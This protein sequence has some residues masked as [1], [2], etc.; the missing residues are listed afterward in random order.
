MHPLLIPQAE[1]VIPLVQASGM[2]G[3]LTFAYSVL[4]GRQPGQVFVDSVINPQTALICNLSGFYFAFGRPEEDMVW[5]LVADWATQPLSAEQTLL[6]V[7]S[8]DWAALF[9]RLLPERTARRSFAYR[10]TPGKPPVNWRERIPAGFRIQPITADLA[11]GIADGTLTGGYGI[12]PW[13]IRIAGGPEAYAAEG[14]GQALVTENGQIASLCGFCALG[15]GEVEFEVGTVWDYRGQGHS[16]T[17][18]SAFLEQCQE[19]GLEPAYTTAYDNLSSIQV[20]NKLGFEE[21]EVV[22]GYPLGLS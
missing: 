2:R 15:N 6:L 22:Q 21:V 9:D 18:C 17:V 12:D 11:R 16:V 14:L 1:Q 13:F 7:P 5:P 4:E 20:A 3:H 19:R 8:P 10:P